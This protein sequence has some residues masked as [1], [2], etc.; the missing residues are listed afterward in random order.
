MCIIKLTVER[1]SVSNSTL[2]Q[3]IYKNG[4]GE[5]NGYQN[6]TIPHAYLNG[7]LQPDESPQQI[8]KASFLMQSM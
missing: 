6:G 3:N 5:E 2:K 8:G 7:M 4:Y 1:N